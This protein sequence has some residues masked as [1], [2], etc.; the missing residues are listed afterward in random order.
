MKQ[1][2]VRGHRLG[3]APTV[4]EYYRDG[5]VA[6]IDCPILVL[7]GRRRDYR[8]VRHVASIHAFCL[9]CA[10]ATDPAARERATEVATSRPSRATGSHRRHTAWPRIG[11]VR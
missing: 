3:D 1:R 7:V 6:V 4:L 9:W 2:V 11:R 10:P 5:L 8:R